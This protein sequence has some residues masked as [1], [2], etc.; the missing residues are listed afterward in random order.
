[1]TRNRI[2][3]AIAECGVWK[4]GSI[5]AA[6]LTLLDEGD[7][8]RELYLYDTFDGMTKPTEEDISYDGVSA[9]E[10]LKNTPVGEGV[11]CVSKLEEVEANIKRT[12][13]PWDKIHFITGKIE[14][15]IPKQNPPQLAILRLDTDWYSSTKHELEHLFPL[16]NQGGFLII[17]DYGHWEG[18]RKA[19]DEFLDT[20]PVKYFL[21]RIDDTGRLLIKQ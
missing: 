7:G 4:G 13:Y 12:E 9:E 18:A 11:W 19:V 8:E 1:M 15:T 17:D 20:L 3:G 5:M 6:A 10:Q 16:L 14:D 2:P 21:H